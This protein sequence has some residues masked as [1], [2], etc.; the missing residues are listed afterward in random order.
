MP[1]L[2]EVRVVTKALSKVVLNKTIADVIVLRD[3]LI[4]E[5][6]PTEFSDVLKNETI[7]KVTNEGKFI[8]F[9]LTNDK[10]MISHLRMEGKYNFY[11]ERTFRKPHDH[12][13][14]EFSDGTNLHYNDTRMF[15]TFHIRSSANY[16]TTNPLNKLA[17]IPAETDPVA[18]HALLQKKN[19]AIKT[20]LLDQTILVGLGNIYVDETLFAVKIHP[21]T[22]AKNLTLDEV[23]ALLN[24]ATNILDHSTQL[25]GSSINSYTSL[26]K[27]EGQFQNFLKVHTKVNQPCWDCQTPI[28]KTKV[29]GRGTYFCKY[30]QKETK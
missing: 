15:G 11:D 16:L 23:K 8:V 28:V 25:G 22:P 1:E 12:V 10:I 27:Q 26:N 3:S 6:T 4:K 18:F 7:L 19:R 5:I 20:T 29:N 24:A 14:F 13:I 2:P 21:Q 17:K 9:H 30:C